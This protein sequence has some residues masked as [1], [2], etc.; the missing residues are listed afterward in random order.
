MLKKGITLKIKGRKR[1]KKPKSKTKSIPKI[2]IT[3][4]NSNGWENITNNK[5]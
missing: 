4:T 5:K 3:N 1:T 2:I